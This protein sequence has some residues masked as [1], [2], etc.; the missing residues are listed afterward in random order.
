MIRVN[1]LKVFPDTGL[2]QGSTGIF[3]GPAGVMFCL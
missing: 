1:P 3:L 2:D